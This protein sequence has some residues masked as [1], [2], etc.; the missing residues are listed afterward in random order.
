MVS[1]TQ[2]RPRSTAVKGKAD[3]GRLTRKPSVAKPVSDTAAE[4][5]VATAD[6]PIVGNATSQKFRLGKVD[7]SAVFASLT[8][9]ITLAVAL[10]G[11]SL[12]AG[13]SAFVVILALTFATLVFAKKGTPGR[14]TAPIPLLLLC[15]YLFISFAWSYD[16]Y[17]WRI[18]VLG[19]VPYFV[20]GICC[21]AVL[22]PRQME[23]ALLN[24]VYFVLLWQVFVFATKPAVAMGVGQIPP[25]WHGSFPHKNSLGNIVLVLLMIVICLERKL[26]VLIPF[27]TWGFV[28]LAFS[29]SRSS[30]VALLIGLLVAAYI[31]LISTGGAGRFTK[32]VMPIGF[33]VPV[34]IAGVAALPFI[35]KAL[36][37]DASLTGRTEIWPP[38]IEAISR[39][40]IFGYGYASVFRNPLLEP[41]RTIESKIPFYAFHPHNSYL[42]IALQVGILGVAF[43]LIVI[44]DVIGKLMRLESGDPRLRICIMGSIVPMLMMGFSE[45]QLLAKQLVIAILFSLM[46]HARVVRERQAAGQSFMRDR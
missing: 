7:V 6:A 5:V 21:C 33:A 16:V 32:L 38:V 44:V 30:Q 20:A 37:K 3:G 11:F 19:L 24:A 18:G 26:K 14:V 34:G 4:T 27:A 25:G 17:G 45:S 46:T 2:L 36:G 29:Q 40:P 42:D 43:Y 22:T 9:M 23:R 28:L 10:G 15:V 35:L 39:N 13:K 12:L 8:M 41:T 1:V 31:A